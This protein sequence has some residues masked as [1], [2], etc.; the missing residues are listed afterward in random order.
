M[1]IATLIVGIALS[2]GLAAAAGLYL[3]L[4]SGTD[5]ALSTQR[6]FPRTGS[7]MGGAPNITRMRRCS[8]I[9]WVDRT[10]SWW[11]GIDRWERWRQQAGVSLSLDW[12]L[13]S[14][15]GPTSFIFLLVAVGGLDPVRGG[16]VVALLWGSVRGVLAT[17]ATRR[18][19]DFQ[20]QLPEA[21]DMMGRSLRAGHSL[22]AGMKMVSDEFPAPVGLEF[23][24]VV[25]EATFGVPLG[26]ALSHLTDRFDSA[27]LRFF[28][29][30]VMIQRE[31]GGNLAEVITSISQMARKRFELASRVRAVSAEGRLSAM[32]L[33]ALPLALAGILYVINAEYIT[34]LF[35]DPLGQTMVTVAGML[36][37]CGAAITK[38]MVTVRI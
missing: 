37:I 13:L 22:L 26:D 38:R 4:P 11:P 14:V 5:P 2:F 28:V 20:R 21:L 29:T 10:L 36:M 34:I 12:L 3:W 15:I 8:P 18:L 24:R 7:G 6:E 1:I 25:E 31:S 9:P 23:G 16:I 30:S 27:A 17:R 33:F 35:Q 19:R 32:V